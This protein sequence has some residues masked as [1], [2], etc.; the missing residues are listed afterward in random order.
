VRRARWLYIARGGWTVDREQR[1][2]APVQALAIGQ[3]GRRRSVSA[4]YGSEAKHRAGKGAGERKD[5]A[6][7]SGV[8]R[9]GIQSV[10]ALGFRVWGRWVPVGLRPGAFWRG[11]E[12]PG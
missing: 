11:R 8:E 12:G 1:H 4:R 3:H 7:E 9:E 2:G 6:G 10:R 5:R